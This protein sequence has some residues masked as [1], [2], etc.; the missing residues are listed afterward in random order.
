MT[1]VTIHEALDLAESAKLFVER[2]A[3]KRD[4]KVGMWDPP[5]R[6]FTGRLG[7]LS[8]KLE[9]LREV[10]ASFSYGEDYEAKVLNHAY[11]DV[12]REME[13]IQREFGIE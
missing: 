8:M 11:E 6:S 10:V 4:P 2:V 3:A 5:S 13:N 1:N 7:P 12:K 9:Y